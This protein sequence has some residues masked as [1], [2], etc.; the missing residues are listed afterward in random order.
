MAWYDAQTGV[1]RHGMEL[2]LGEAFQINK[3]VD[4]VSQK[5]TLSLPPVPG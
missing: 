1:S 4:L 5:P 3:Q 2:T